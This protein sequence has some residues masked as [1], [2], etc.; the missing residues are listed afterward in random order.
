[1]FMPN[2][3]PAASAGRFIA[4]AESGANLFS[5]FVRAYGLSLEPR[6]R[7]FAYG[8]RASSFQGVAFLLLLA[9]SGDR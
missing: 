5:E 4:W 3:F 2:P 7:L 8:A 9:I 6:V 1:M